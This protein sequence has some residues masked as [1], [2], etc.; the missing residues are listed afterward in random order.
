MEKILVLCGE[1]PMPIHHHLSNSFQKY[2]IQKIR[3]E[4]ILNRE[5]SINYVDR[6]SRNMG[7][8]DM[9]HIWE[10]REVYDQSKSIDL[11]NKFKH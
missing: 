11:S 2:L 10:V 7:P 5:A 4:F 3:V 9:T 1:G 8:Y 6:I